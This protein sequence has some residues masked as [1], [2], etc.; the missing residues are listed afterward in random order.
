[1]TWDP[2]KNQEFKQLCL[3][4]SI[5][6]RRAETSKRASNVFAIA[7]T[8]AIVLAIMGFWTNSHL[9]LMQLRAELLGEIGHVF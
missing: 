4:E 8:S 6:L 7:I 9:T 5:E 2:D 3:F 1:M